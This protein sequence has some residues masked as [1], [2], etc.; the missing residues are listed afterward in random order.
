[1][2]KQKTSLVNRGVAW[3]A[4]LVYFIQGALG[5]ASVALPLYLRA[6][7]FSIAK[8]AWIS[9]LVSVP[10]FF[11]I[12][13]GAL[14]DAVPL[15]HLR[16]KPYL[17]ISCFLSCAGW[18]LLAVLPAREL[19]L[20]ISMFV[21]QLG[22]AATDVITDGLVVDYSGE[23]SAQ[24]YQS[25]SWGF[26][27]L[28]ALLG[29]VTGGYLA[30]AIP[31]K[32][33]F[34]VTSTLPL[35]ALPAIFQ[36]H[37]KPEIKPPFSILAPIVLS[38][39]LI[40]QGDLRWFSLLVVA[41]SFG[42]MFGTPFFFYLNETLHFGE[43]FLGVLQ[44]T[45]WA[46]A[47]IGCFLFLGFF[48]QRPVK[49]ALYWAIG[50]GFANTLLALLVAGQS[51]AFLIFFFSGIMDYITLLPFMASAAKLAHG[52]GA[53]GSLFAVLMSILNAAKALAAYVGGVL[54]GFIGLQWL[55]VFSACSVLLGFIILP[56][57]KT[58]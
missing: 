47:V 58:L 18:C 34:L 48:R 42:A 12:L 40:A 24:T 27:S 28:G 44:S 16:R 49:Q 10:W 36:L 21:F 50:I 38:L 37:E 43:F 33:I 22:S 11:K 57:L 6:Q 13:Y 5:I 51:S 30:A 2:K 39:R 17:V 52:T 19:W 3:L 7:G 23:G 1:M 45:A 31:P 46:G 41:T 55:I 20:I 4:G 25:I 53:E 9:A 32:L 54:F 35:L 26:R 15:F 56:R 29:G 14:S 8:I